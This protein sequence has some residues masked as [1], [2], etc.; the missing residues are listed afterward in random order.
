VEE[1]RRE[2]PL[3]VTEQPF[4]VGP[5]QAAEVAFGVVSLRQHYLTVRV[6]VTVTPEQGEPVRREV[7]VLPLAWDGSFEALGTGEDQV[8]DGQRSLKLGPSLEGYQHRTVSLWLLPGHSYRLSVQMRRDGFEARVYGTAVVVRSWQGD[9]PIMRA[10]VDTGKVNEW[11]T[12]SYEFTTPLDL[13]RALLYL[14]NV[15]SP[16]TAWFDDIYVEDLGPVASG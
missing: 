13:E 16:D 12:A 11:Q 5:Q 7:L 4:R 14:Y 3:T 6:A 8:V 1:A 9:L 10:P 15:G 2:L